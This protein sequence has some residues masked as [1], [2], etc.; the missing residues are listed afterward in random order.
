MDE[1]PGEAVSR[2]NLT[3]LLDKVRDDRGLDLAQYRPRYLERRVA[4]RLQAL[5]LPTYRRYAS[6]L[7]EHPEEYA[8]LLDALTIGV[9][10]FFRDSSVFELFRR[11]IVPELMQQKAARHQRVIRA[12]SAGCAT[13]E[14]TYS[15]A[16]SL[17][18]ATGQGS[19]GAHAVQVLGTDI[20]QA[21]LETARRAEYPVAQLG[22][23]PEAERQ[24]YVDVIGDRFRVRPEVTDHVRFEYLNL[25]GDRP[26]RIA[27]VVFCRN[28]F[29]YFNRD[30]QERMLSTFWD[31]L[32]KGG[33]LVL[34]RTERLARGLAQHFDVVSSSERIYRKPPG[35][36]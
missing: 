26:T 20:D 11:E 13:G 15:V 22:Q 23:I 35:L 30:E 4:T 2:G 8:K 9:T 28:V 17:I 27:D 18:A 33:Y 24:R 34:G 7:D 3:R 5:S 29:I 6:Y 12:W 31:A 19:G 1:H 10:Q 14:E 21:A 36:H 25:F 16:M 32:T